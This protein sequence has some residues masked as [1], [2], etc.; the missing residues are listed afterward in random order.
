MPE[1]QKTLRDESTDAGREIWQKVD[2]A[3][4]QLPD[5]LR[6]RVEEKVASLNRS[7]PDRPHP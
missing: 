2:R 6:L 7:K 5:W 3:A 4:S 1:H